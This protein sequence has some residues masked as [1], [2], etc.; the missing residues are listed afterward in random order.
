M[1]KTIKIIDLLNKIANGKKL[2]KRIKWRDKIWDYIEKEQDYINHNIYFFEGFTQIRT[3]D[4]VTDTVE[5]IEDTPKKIE[6]IKVLK[7]DTFDRKQKSAYENMVKLAD[8]LNEIIDKIN[9]MES[10]E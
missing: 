2:P 7:Y 5:I 9:E 10:K 4:F 6:K 8:K 3:K 1:N